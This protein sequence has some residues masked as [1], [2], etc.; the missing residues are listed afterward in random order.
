MTPAR[1]A[2]LGGI[3]AAAVLV[4]LL[5]L[6]GSDQ[7][8]VKATF[9]TAGQLVNGNEVQVGGK[10]V[11][12][13]AS[14]ELT[15]DGQAEVEMEIDS[16]FEPLHEGTHASIRV[17]SLSGI[18]GR[19]VSLTPGP[20]DA[21]EIADGGRID[22]DD[23]T[24]PVDLDQLFN[25]LDPKTR[26]GLQEIIQGGATQYDGK[27]AEANEAAKYFN[28]AL[29]TS[30]RLMNE[31]IRDDERFE[32][33]IVDTATVVGALAERR[34]DL[35]ELV[36][37]A[38]ATTR[39][40]GQENAALARALGLLPPTLRK[41][42]TT[43]VNLRAALG[44]LDVLVAESKPATKD[45]A[46]FFRALRP[47]VADAEP[48]IE[49]LRFLINKSGP[50]NDL[51]DLTKKQPKLA[52][53]A[54]VAFP[55]AIRALQQSQPVIE[56]IRPYTPDFAGW[57]TKFGQSAAN[58]DAHGHFA[59]I[60][61]LF[62]AFSLTSSPLLGQVLTPTQNA[63][64]LEGLETTQSFRCPGGSTQPPPDGSAPWRDT[65]GDLECD[66]STVPPGP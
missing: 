45:L 1:I 48:T 28:P 7:Y 32:S 41:A 51:I 66:P 12:K 27:A 23:T 9:Q 6:S 52:R 59:R 44:D 54:S 58:Y 56:Y 33:F 36:T 2:A 62:N 25:T 20:N 16:E 15:E 14:I 5:M 8:S 63:T 13:V 65:D 30:S 53:L 61:P 46:P 34:D 42:N 17:G 19:Y 4:G 57:L 60:Q 24:T 40:I 10:P 38:N 37:N 26:K 47:L 3:V 22:A 49:D 21:G 50:G 39:A 35:A 55:R 18:A 31:L 64:R 43:F 11:G 29:S